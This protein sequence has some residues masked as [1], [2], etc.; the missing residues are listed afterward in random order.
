[1]DRDYTGRIREIISTADLSVVTIKQI[2]VQL[3]QEYNIVLSNSPQKETINALILQTLATTPLDLSDKST[4]P[5]LP[6]IKTTKKQMNPT[7]S[8]PEEMVVKR[9]RVAQND[10]MLAM[11]IQSDEK[12]YET[13][14][15]RGAKSVVTVKQKRERKRT[16]TSGDDDK[17][18]GAIKKQK[19]VSNLRVMLRASEAL[20][21]ITGSARVTRQDVG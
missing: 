6:P 17:Q 13:R 4:T 2:R 8:Q 1:M 19:K 20:Q 18:E 21:V 15:G 5:E 12:Y 10:S 16:S 9:D 11:Q 3:E 14:N 7:S